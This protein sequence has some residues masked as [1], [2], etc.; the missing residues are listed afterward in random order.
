MGHRKLPRGAGLLPRGHPAQNARKSLGVPSGPLSTLPAWATS[1]WNLDSDSCLL[2]LGGMGTDAQFGR[3]L[4]YRHGIGLNSFPGSPV[5]FSVVLGRS[6][7]F[8]PKDVMTMS[9]RVS[10]M[11]PGRSPSLH[12]MLY[13]LKGVGLTPARNCLR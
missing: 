3:S 8:P 10:S 5:R 6:W 1:G 13:W 4:K 2:S 12:R 7:A 9:T 11:S